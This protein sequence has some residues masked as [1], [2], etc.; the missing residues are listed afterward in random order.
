MVQVIIIFIMTQRHSTLLCGI[1]E[2]IYSYV[3]IAMNHM[4][5]EIVEEWFW[6]LEHCGGC[7]M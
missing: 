7:E 6:K 4:I 5:Y 1:M 2:A 3:F